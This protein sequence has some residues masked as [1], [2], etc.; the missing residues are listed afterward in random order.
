[1]YIVY[2]DIT[3]Q[4]YMGTINFGWGDKS[5]RWSM[6]ELRERTSKGVIVVSNVT[7]KLPLTSK[8]PSGKLT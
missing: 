6:D 8:I 7:G 4:S 1:M 3:Q 5:S 2:G